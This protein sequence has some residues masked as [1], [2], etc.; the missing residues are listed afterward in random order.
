MLIAIL[1]S[2][3]ISPSDTLR[4]SLDE[5]LAR[6]HTANTSVRAERAVAQATRQGPLEAS[7]GLL[8]TLQLDIQGYRTTDPVAAF[9][10]RLRQEGFSE[11]DFALD[12]LNRPDPFGN[13]TSAATVQLPLISPEGWFGLAA[14]RHAA[15]AQ[16]AVADRAAGAVSLQVTQTYWGAVLARQRVG[17]LD[18][19]LAA[20]RAHAQQADAL[21]AQGLVTGLDA[22]LAR[23]RAAETEAQK[24]TAE[25]EAQN[26]V[27]ALKWLLALSEET[28]IGL[29][30]SL[31]LPVTASCDEAECATSNRGDVTALGFGMRAAS[32]AV[33]R[34][35]AS[36]L[37]SLGAFGTLAHHS[38]TAPFGGGSGDWTVGIALTWRPF[39][40]LAGVGAVRR[41]R[42]E[43]EAAAARHEGAQQ[44]AMLEVVQAVR[45]SDAAR[46]RVGVAERAAA[47]AQEALDQARL[48][49]RTGT[50]SMTEL[51][52]VQAAATAAT[53]NLLVARHDVLVTGATVDF[54]YGVQDR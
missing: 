36:N 45:R 6:A 19:A 52:D 30:D 2:L 40:G 8:P 25:A 11:Q 20:A 28:P 5:A 23:I 34:S 50:S 21:R 38:G 10:G 22:R 29:V 37:P 31:A 35:W 13:W 48:R 17:T 27:S 43:Y 39:Q 7:R 15:D 24:L 32:S 41:A 14:A 33:R 26:A 54:A 47:E 12:A 51:L 4:L 49:Y 46:A 9:G 53:M 16:A 44:Q 1:L 42:A 18:T 3:Q